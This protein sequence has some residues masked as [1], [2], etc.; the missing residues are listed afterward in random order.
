M[1]RPVGKHFSRITQKVYADHGQAWA[2]LLSN[3]E[4]IIGNEIAAYSVPEKIS[5]PTI[6]KERST[7]SKYQKIGGVLTLRVAFGRAIDVQYSTP[8]IIDKIN[9]YYGYNSIA[10][11]KILQGKLDKP[12]VRHKKQLPELNPIQK[13]LLIAQTA[14]IEN[15]DLK[16]A[17]HRLAKGVFGQN[18]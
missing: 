3:W 11:I 18:K 4:N 14:E 9:A 2:E 15:Q 17:I 13:S 5:W 8:Q 6:P 16:N 10:Q 12:E 1:M 7:A